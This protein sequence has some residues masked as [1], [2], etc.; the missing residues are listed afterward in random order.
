MIAAIPSAVR[1]R[2][3]A[4]RSFGTEQAGHPPVD[5]NQVGARLQ[6]VGRMIAD[7]PATALPI[8]FAVGV[9]LG[10]LVKRT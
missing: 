8:A 5:R 3:T 1:R 9:F 6:R 10:W 2:V 4:H 7:H